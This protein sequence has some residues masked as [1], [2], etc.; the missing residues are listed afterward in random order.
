MLTVVLL[1]VA[2]TV[3]DTPKTRAC[4]VCDMK[5]SHKAELKHHYKTDH[6]DLS[7]QAPVK[8]LLP[9]D[10][11]IDNAAYV[12]GN[13]EPLVSSADGLCTFAVRTLQ[14]LL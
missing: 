10:C 1:C 3:L 12:I 2:V 11:S 8:Q 14:C 4:K 9:D 7:A 13:V 5:F 6:K